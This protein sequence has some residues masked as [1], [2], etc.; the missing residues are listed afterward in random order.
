MLPI[1]KPSRDGNNVAY[2]AKGFKL[3]FWT[4]VGLFL[5]GFQPH[6]VT[7]KAD[8]RLTVSRLVGMRAPAYA[9]EFLTIGNHDMTEVSTSFTEHQI[10]K[11]PVGAF[12]WNR[13]IRL[14]HLLNITIL[15][16]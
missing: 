4:W 3:R 9:F 1:Q 16:V 15:T 5:D 8:A 2:K 12:S 7:F 10:L 13:N 11:K 6:L 14:S